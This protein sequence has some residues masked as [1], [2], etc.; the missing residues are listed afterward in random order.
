MVVDVVKVDRT[1]SSDAINRGSSNSNND[2]G[3]SG[4]SSSG[5]LL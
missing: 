1:C 5:S 3:S 2:R 4:G